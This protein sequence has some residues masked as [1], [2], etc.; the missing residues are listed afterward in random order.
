MADQSWFWTPE[1][2]AKEAEADE[3]LRLGRYKE[4]ATM[5]EM[6]AVL[7]DEAENALLIESGILPKLI[8]AAMNEKHSDDWRAELAA[9]GDTNEQ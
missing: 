8:A 5:D 7:E 6:I 1:W 3:D 4:F 2:Q 9:L